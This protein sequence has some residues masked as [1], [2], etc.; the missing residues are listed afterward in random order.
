MKRVLDGENE[1]ERGSVREER[2]FRKKLG[3]NDGRRQRRV[4]DAGQREGL[5][6]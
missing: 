1:E 5:E 2:V 3:R 6:G 4:G